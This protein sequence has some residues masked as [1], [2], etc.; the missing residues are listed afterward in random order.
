M[1]DTLLPAIKAFDA[2]FPAMAAETGTESAKSMGV[3]TA[4]RSSD[5]TSETLT[6]NADPGTIA[7]VIVLRELTGA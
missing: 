3:A 7:V 4:G 5:L 1:I 2:R 6:I